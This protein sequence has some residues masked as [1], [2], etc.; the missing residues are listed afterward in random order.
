MA[1]NDHV[2]ESRLGAFGE[3]LRALT[4]GYLGDIDAWLLAA[5]AEKRPG[6]RVCKVTV[7]MY[8]SQTESPTPSQESQPTKRRSRKRSP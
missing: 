4:M 8:R 3:F 5:S 1:E 7:G 6:E 2:P